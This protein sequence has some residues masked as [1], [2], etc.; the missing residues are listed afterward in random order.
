[1]SKKQ[2]NGG[3]EF[4]FSRNPHEAEARERWG[5]EAVDASN[6]KLGS[7]TKEGRKALGDRMNAMYARLAGLRNGAAD[8]EEA[9][10][11]IGEWFEFL[12]SGFGYTYSLEAFKGLGQMYVD[13]E[14]FAKNI[15]K[16]GDGLAAF[17]R[18]AM[19]V[20]AD[21]NAQ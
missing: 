15:D 10:A 6:R 17:M 8:S 12:N 3:F 20:Y 11:A 21:R 7:M 1:M 16:F 2:S 4:D 5:D 19:A 13:D 18:D 14:R 9:Q